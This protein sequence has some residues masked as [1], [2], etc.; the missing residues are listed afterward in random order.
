MI[1][2]GNGERTTTS[3]VLEVARRSP[4]FGK[5]SIPCSFRSLTQ[6]RA[7]SEDQAPSVGSLTRS[8]VCLSPLPHLPLFGHLSWWARLWRCDRNPHRHLPTL[9][10]LA[11]TP[12]PSQR[13]LVPKA[14]AIR[15]KA[16]LR[17]ST[18]RWC[19]TSDT[20]ENARSTS[21]AVWHDTTRHG[22]APCP[23]PLGQDALPHINCSLPVCIPLCR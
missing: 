15:R 16:C 9:R 17:R 13:R 6:P 20:T 12:H 5:S 23:R 10:R 1:S 2:V 19:A 3:R 14:F 11:P 18:S 22:T 21:A 4:R 8:T 7:I